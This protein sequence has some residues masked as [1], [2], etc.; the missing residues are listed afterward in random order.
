MISRNLALIGALTTVCTAAT[1]CSGPDVASPVGAPVWSVIGQEISATPGTLFFAS[2]G[3]DPQS[4]VAATNFAGVITANVDAGGACAVTP[5]SQSAQVAPG[6]GGMKTA[7]FQVRP[8]AV[9]SCR[10]HLNDKKGNSVL[11]SAEVQGAAACNYTLTLNDAGTSIIVAG[12]SATV[13]SGGGTLTA[14]VTTGSSCA[15]QATSNASWLHVAG[16]SGAV[17]GSGT[18]SYSVDVLS[19]T[20]T[21]RTGTIQLIGVAANAAGTLSAT[22]VQTH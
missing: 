6:S 12:N 15:W 7:A 14:D 13:V 10:I 20:G 4:V 21:D 1:A 22:I 18:I 5:S 2:P 3:A 9:G 8:I 11:V 16:P 17:T 19:H